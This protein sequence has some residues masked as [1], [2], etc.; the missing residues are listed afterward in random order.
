[1]NLDNVIDAAIE[2][3]EES[4]NKHE[5]LDKIELTIESLSESY[6]FFKLSYIVFSHAATTIEE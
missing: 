6:F 1:M 3:L 5:S 2:V 4:R